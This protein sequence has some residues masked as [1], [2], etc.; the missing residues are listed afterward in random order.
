MNYI[1]S[2]NTGYGDHIFEGA[3]LLNCG[4]GEDS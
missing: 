2:Q 4:V 1:S 3:K